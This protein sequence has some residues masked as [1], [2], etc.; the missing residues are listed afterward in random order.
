[1]MASSNEHLDV[2]RLLLERG[3]NVRLRNRNGESAL[4]LAADTEND[5]VINMLKRAGAKADVKKVEKPIIVD[6]EEDEDEEISGG[7]DL[8]GIESDDVEPDDLEIDD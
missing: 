2:V 7:T 3:A 6:D 4:N 8:E 5:D 1:M